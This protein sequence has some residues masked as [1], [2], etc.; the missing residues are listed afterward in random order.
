MPISQ[1]ARNIAR[2]LTLAI[3][4]G[5]RLLRERGEVVMNISIGEPTNKAPI[6]AIYRTAGL[7]DIGRVINWGAANGQTFDR[8]IQ[9][10]GYAKLEHMSVKEGFFQPPSLPDYL[11]PISID[12]LAGEFI[13]PKLGTGVRPF[14]ALGFGEPSLTAHAPAVAIAVADAI[15]ISIFKLPSDPE[16]VLME[17]DRARTEVSQ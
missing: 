6:S 2:L 12:F 14:G 16:K 3:N 10:L 8:G 17:L 4:E 7:H 15:G 1:L 11:I 5:A 13:L 9:S